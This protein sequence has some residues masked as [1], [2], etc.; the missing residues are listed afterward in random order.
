MQL[1]PS[2]GG[3]AGGAEKS[4]PWLLDPAPGPKLLSGL[5]DLLEGMESGGWVGSDIR[6]LERI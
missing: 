4:W 5:E 6:L 2:S 1:S 3:S